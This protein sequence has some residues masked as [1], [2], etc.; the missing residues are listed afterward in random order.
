MNRQT[1]P[2]ESINFVRRDPS[3]KLVR[4]LKATGIQK[5]IMIIKEDDKYFAYDD[6]DILS[7][8]E[9]LGTKEVSTIVERKTPGYT[10]DMFR[11]KIRGELRNVDLGSGPVGRALRGVYG[12]YQSIFGEKKSQFVEFVAATL[13]M[14]VKIINISM[15]S[16]D[17]AGVNLTDF[18]SM[19]DDVKK[20]D[21]LRYKTSQKFKK[22]CPLCG[23]QV[24][25]IDVPDEVMPTIISEIVIKRV[26]FLVGD[27]KEQE[28]TTT[29]SLIHHKIRSLI[30]RGPVK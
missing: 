6:S 25:G 22:V 28:R 26:R 17:D 18:L 11:I 15:R 7:A 5:P 3:D 23:W 13:G 14:P 24:S 4:S 30:E 9:K 20:S 16:E 8:A 1:I 21:S 12:E 29:L 2:L 10:K 27:M 19:I